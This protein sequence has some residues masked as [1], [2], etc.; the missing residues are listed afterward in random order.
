MIA[1][2]ESADLATR[3][4]DEICTKQR[5]KPGQLTV[6]ADRGS[7]MMSKPLVLLMED[8]GNRK[9]HSRPRVSND[10][11]VSE[12][13]FKT[14]KCRPDYPGRFG[15]LQDARSWAASFFTWYNSQH[16]HSGIGL[17]SPD[18]VHYGKAES[19]L[20]RRQQV[21]EGAYAARDRN[22]SLK[23]L[24]LS[25]RYSRPSGLTGQYR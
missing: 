14:K 3:V 25:R 13:Q 2:R 1:D 12:S 7:S 16:Y 15:S 10:N 6:H 8:L 19:A 20:I 22:G 17:L 18:T 5:I 21:L 9:C 23:D 4:I 24:R 11:P